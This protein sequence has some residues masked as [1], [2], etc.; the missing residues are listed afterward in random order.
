M[1]DSQT[2]RN[3][4]PRKRRRRFFRRKKLLTLAAIALTVAISIW[5]P[6]LFKSTGHLLW[7]A[8]GPAMELAL[9]ALAV[10]I[11]HRR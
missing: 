9:T 7:D 5:C 1:R 3:P 4:K 11:Q 8:K 10:H 6:A 2:K